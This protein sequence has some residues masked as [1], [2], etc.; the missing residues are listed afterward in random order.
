MNTSHL[1]LRDM[2]VAAMAARLLLS[3]DE[4]RRG[5]ADVLGEREADALD[6]RLGEWLENC[7]LTTGAVG[8]N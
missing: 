3:T 7:H 6:Q 5:F 2:R 4:G 8:V 1:S